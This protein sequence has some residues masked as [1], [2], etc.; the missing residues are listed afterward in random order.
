MVKHPAFN[1]TNDGSIPS[2]STSINRE[3]I[4]LVL[5]RKLDEEILIDNKINIIVLEIKRSQVKL[6][7]EAPKS[8]RILRRE[9]MDEPR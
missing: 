7:F 4:V 5:T 9:I 2:G 6:G 3:V 8:C 1:R